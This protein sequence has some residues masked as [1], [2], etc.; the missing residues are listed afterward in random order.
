[1][2]NDIEKLREESKKKIDEIIDNYETDNN[3][4][5]TIPDDNIY[6]EF[7]IDNK[8]YIAFSENSN[9][10]EEIEMIFAKVE[11]VDGEKILRNIETDEEYQ[12]VINEFDRR[13]EFIT[14]EEDND[15]EY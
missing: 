4:I 13:L 9:D 12:K 8:N 5:L 2:N 6:M 14:I 7:D 3:N 10:V 11:Y 1:M 15:N